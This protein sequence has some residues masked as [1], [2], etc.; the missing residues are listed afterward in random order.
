[1]ATTATVPV[2]RTP[3]NSNQ[4]KGFWAAWGG[5]C[6]DGMDAFIY[7]LVLVSALTE[8]LPRS[9]IAA[10]PGNIGFYGSVL[11]ALFLIGWGLSMLW[12]PVAGRLRRGAALALTILCYSL[13]TFLCGVATDVWQLAAYRVLA[14]IGIGGEWFIGATFVAEAGPA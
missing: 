5:W 10:T 14:G 8:L 13:F 4:I 2:R 12:G 6:L 3:L 11:F 9:G 1:M 7:S